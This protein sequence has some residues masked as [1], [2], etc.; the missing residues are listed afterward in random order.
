M[1]YIALGLNQL[2]A[3]EYYD[4][5]TIETHKG[6]IPM[7]GFSGMRPWTDS[8]CFFA[9]VGKDFYEKYDPWFTDNNISSDGI[10]VVS[11]MT[12]YCVVKYDKDMNFDNGY[13]FTHNWEDADFWR[14]WGSDLDEIVKEDTK[15]VYF[16][17]PPPPFAPNDIWEKLFSLREEK[18]IKIMW[19]PNNAHT[20]IKD[21]EATTELL[22]KIDMASFNLAEGKEIFGVDS[23][24]ELL[25]LLKSFNMDLTLLRMGSD[26]MYVISKGKSWKIGIAEFEPKKEVVDVTGCGNTST[27]GAMVAYCMGDD[28]VMCGI[29]GSISAL[30]NL[31]Q[32]GPYPKF[33]EKEEREAL[34]IAQNFYDS[35]EWEKP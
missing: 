22:S 23:E 1:E 16:C 8:I 33:T 32:F 19:E 5:S 25:E 29:K 13:F 35:Y 21:K 4:K 24:K 3:I 12:P 2:D 6:G 10:K 27:A 15:A 17:S 26:G 11:E 20:S 34:Q 7:Y 31:L 14:P 18:G 30:Y 28:P 9:R